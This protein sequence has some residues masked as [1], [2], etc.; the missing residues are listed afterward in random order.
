MHHEAIA[1]LCLD[2]GRRGMCSFLKAQARPVGL[3][4]VLFMLQ[5]LQAPVLVTGL[6]SG[7]S[8]NESGDEHGA[9]HHKYAN[10]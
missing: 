1:R 2:A 8:N 4:F 6:M 7:R 3:E 5:A 10:K 9:E